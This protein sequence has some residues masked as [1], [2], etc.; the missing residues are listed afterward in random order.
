LLMLLRAVLVQAVLVQAVLVPLLC[1]LSAP[2][3]PR[4]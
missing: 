2:S 3:P 1:R 4:G